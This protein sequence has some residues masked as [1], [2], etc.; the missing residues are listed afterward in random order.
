M[1]RFESNPVKF[2]NVYRVGSNSAGIFVGCGDGLVGYNDGAKL[3][4]ID[5]SV[6]TTVGAVGALYGK[7][8]LN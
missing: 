6:G 3:G 5:G 8:G 1:V 4:N 2:S 7:N